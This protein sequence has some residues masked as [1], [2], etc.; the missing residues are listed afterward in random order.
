MN[1][2]IIFI[3]LVVILI[4]SDIIA[5][6]THD[7]TVANFSFT[8]SQLTIKVGD[9]VRWTNS[10][11]FHN[12]VADDNSFTSGAASTINWV[13][14]HR[15]NSPGSNPYYCSVHGG[16]GGVG[17][18][19]VITVQAATDVDDKVLTTT[20]YKLFQ[21]FPNPFNPSTIITFQ[22]FVQSSVSLIVY[23]I[24]GNQV[25]T[26]LNEEKPAGKY[27]VNF[28]A[29]NTGKLLSS[30]IYYYKMRAG[31]FSEIKKMVLIK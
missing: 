26:L 29:S 11:G 1:K 9:I 8:P 27:T 14:E 21:N 13:Y 23:D 5:Q 28:D 4:T 22:V 30:G 18:S 16:P 10:G 19:G 25:A 2:I 17:M 20:D 31:N 12:V 24:I 15:F 6:T 3:M 7:V